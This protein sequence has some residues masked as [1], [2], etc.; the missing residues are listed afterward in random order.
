MESKE[1]LEQMDEIRKRLPVSFREAKEA[2]EKNEYDIPSAL[3]VLEESKAGEHRIGLRQ[4]ERFLA[5]P[6]LRLRRRGQ[7]LIG[8]SPLAAA[9]L[10][11]AG[12]RRPKLLLLSA[13]AVLLSGTDILI[14]YQES[15]YSLQKAI[16][17]KSQR[18]ADNVHE[19]KG[20]LDDRL[21]D[22]KETGFRRE[23]PH[24]GQHYFTFQI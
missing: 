22:I 17:N 13:A 5:D 3:A 2:L 18:A 20:M 11:L 1:L 8:L 4:A 14:N 9:A 10:L 7:D 23:S 15:Q 6:V 19:M 16:S 12:I 24:H 21:Q